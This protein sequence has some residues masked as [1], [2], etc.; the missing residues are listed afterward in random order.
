MNCQFKHCNRKAAYFIGWSTSDGKKWGMVCAT[1]D[2][3]LGRKNLLN[4]MSLEEAIE[5]DRKS[6]EDF[7]RE[8]V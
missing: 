1:H 6:R 2:K 8:E 5:S 4:Y 7:L 3:E